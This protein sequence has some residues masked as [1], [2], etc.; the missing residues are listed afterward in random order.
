MVLRERFTVGDRTFAV[1]AE[2]LYDGEAA[3]W[4]ARLL[5]VP[6]DRSLDRSVSS[7]AV[8]GDQH[9]DDLLERVRNLSDRELARVFGSIKLP[10]P[11]TC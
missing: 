7:T 6:L 5:F 11:K 8:K 4:K 9:R 10:R 2:P 1:L 3:E